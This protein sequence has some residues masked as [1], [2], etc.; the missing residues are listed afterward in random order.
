[1]HIEVAS[2]EYCISG[3]TDIA[4]KAGVEDLQKK[5]SFELNFGPHHRSIIPTILED[6]IELCLFSETTNHS[7]SF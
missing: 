4:I 2:S 5:L 6:Q 1:M 3:T 7:K